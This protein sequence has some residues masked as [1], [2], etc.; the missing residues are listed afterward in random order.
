MRA[1]ATLALTILGGALY[2]QPASVI[3]PKEGGIYFDEDSILV[4][5]NPDTGATSYSIDIDITSQF[6][7]PLVSLSGLT[8]TSATVQPLSTGKYYL[9]MRSYDGA[10]LRN[11]WV[12]SFRTFNPETL[13]NALAWYR[14]DLGVIDSS[15]LISEWQNQLS[16]AYTLQQPAVSKR[17][18]ST[19]GINGNPSVSF[20]GANDGLSIPALPLG[21]FTIFSI[22]N[23]TPT[24]PRIVYEHSASATSNDGC[25]ISTSTCAVSYAR[26]LGQ[27]SGKDFSPMPSM[28]DAHLITQLFKSSA[29]S[30]LL[31]RNQVQTNVVT[32]CGTGNPGYAL[33]SQPFFLGS[34]ANSFVFF[35]GFFGDLLIVNESLPDSTVALVEQFL[36]QRYFPCVDLG[37]DHD[38]SY[39]F[40]G[41]TLEAPTYYTTYLWSTGATTSSIAVTKPGK[42]WVRATD[43]L[44]G[45][46]ADTIVVNHPINL[47]Y[48]DPICAGMSTYWD[49]QLDS[50]A[51]TFNWSTGNTNGS[52]LLAGA[53]TYSVTVT[54]TNGCSAVFS[55]TFTE[56]QFAA[57]VSLGPD[58]SICAGEPISLVSGNQGIVSYNWSTGG[59]SDTAQIWSS[60][61]Y[62]VTV[63]NVNG[64]TASDD[65]NI[66][67]LGGALPVPNFI[68]PLNCHAD[69]VEFTDL[70]DAGTDVIVAWLW[71]FDDG[72][73]STVQHPRHLYNI[74]GTY[75]VRLTISTS[76]GCSNSI[77]KPVTV[78]PSPVADFEWQGECLGDETYFYDLSSVAPGNLVSYEW[79]FGDGSTSPDQNPIYTFAS[80]GLK[81]VTL[82]VTSNTGC[83]DTLQHS[84]YLHAPPVAQFAFDSVCVGAAT[85]FTDQSLPSPSGGTLSWFWVFGDGQ[86]SST[87]HNTHLYQNA[88]VYAVTLYVQDMSYGCFDDTTVM[89]NI[90]NLPQAAIGVDDIC[91]GVLAQFT[92]LSVG[93]GK[94]INSW[95]WSYEDGGSD[96][97]QHPLHLFTDTGTY[98]VQLIV[99]NG[100]PGCADAQT[101]S[102]FVN[103]LP[104]PSFAFNPPAGAAPIDVTFDNNT[105][106]A[107]G[108]HTFEWYVEDSLVGTDSVPTYHFENNGI[109]HVRL[110]A[111]SD[112]GCV[113]QFED[114]IYIVLPVLDVAIQ[115]VVLTPNLM[116]NGDVVISVGAQVVNAGTVKV[117][118]MDM[119][120]SLQFG[121]PMTEHWETPLF[122]SEAEWF[123]FSS[124]FV[125]EG[126]DDDFVCVE[127]RNPNGS[128]DEHPENNRLCEPIELGLL[129]L[130]PYPNPA[131]DLINFMILLPDD[132]QIDVLA[133]DALGRLVHGAEVDGLQGTNAL[134]FST[135]GDPPGPYVWQL[136][137]GDIRVQKKVL[138]AR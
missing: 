113:A 86:A 11:S 99:G 126:V 92:D 98:A 129:V 21:E 71:D 41:T 105:K 109:Y 8:Q 90:F 55:H 51:Y 118:E 133:Y 91:V 58:R 73:T 48:P 124:G 56:D 47:D 30:H 57:T 38:I 50:T 97:M 65:I 68:T 69:S 93:F 122:A 22:W 16:S 114:S 103:P 134:S 5:W 60:G 64:C 89:V 15:G 94:V 42:Y 44:G 77:T 135:A 45:S 96:S 3:L 66:T 72:N 130:G 132:R 121:A 35:R 61:N 101:V 19:A 137:I 108:P 33:V 27:G 102:V 79:D 17:P 84:F 128:D 88:G 123:S 25:F 83:R 36:A 24:S 74:P 31:R 29:N 10:L 95:Q 4:T 136:I 81:N 70:S 13:V 40:C 116:A 18:L 7:A 107:D 39:G 37:V 85:T 63:T 2:A 20:D 115:Q 104:E 67:I 76:S 12:G 23:A 14:P 125:L 87:Q 1:L 75:M 46:Y 32:N 52:Q 28:T 34:R 26:R 53:G 6:T 82:V 131:S 110:V 78:N 127:V 62:S 54:D 117:D 119:L 80:S 43:S 111:T 138:V 9:R 106:P 100:L 112:H 49:L 120:A 59:Q